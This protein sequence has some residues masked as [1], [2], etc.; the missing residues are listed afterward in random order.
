MGTDKA[1]LVSTAAGERR[2]RILKSLTPII[3][4]SDVRQQDHV[5][6]KEAIGK[7]SPPSTLTSHR[8]T[9]Q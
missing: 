6:D 3:L 5:G 1:L 8:V 7:L 2:A 4:K 9:A